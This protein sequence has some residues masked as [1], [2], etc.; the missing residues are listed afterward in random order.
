MKK[1]TKQDANFIRKWSEVIAKEGYV[2]VPNLLI[3]HLGDMKVTPVEFAVIVGLLSHMWDEKNPYPAVD[4]IASYIGRSR[5]STQAAARS[6]DVD[7]GHGKGLILRIPRGNMTNEYDI[8]PL[9]KRLESYAQPIEKSIPSH[10]K[11]GDSTYRE[12]D[13]EEYHPNKTQEKRRSTSSG[14]L[15]S[16]GDVLKDRYPTI[17]IKR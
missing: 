3:R 8:R 13:T 1:V 2:Q 6:L 16:A 10:R 12:V 17:A 5:N 14:K 7:K 9:I 4:T 11:S 15:S